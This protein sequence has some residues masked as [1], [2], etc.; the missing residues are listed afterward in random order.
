MFGKN[1][2]LN[3]NSRIVQRVNLLSIILPNELSNLVI[4]GVTAELYARSELASIGESAQ[5]VPSRGCYVVSSRSL[6]CKSFKI[7]VNF[8]IEV[9]K[10]YR[11]MLP[12]SFLDN[13]HP[14]SMRCSLNLQL[15]SA[16]EKPQQPNRPDFF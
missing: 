13:F 10:S 14:L 7:R 5:L 15:R 2:R 3:F 16:H 6:S 8:W 9:L 1:L 12:T 4:A 11:H